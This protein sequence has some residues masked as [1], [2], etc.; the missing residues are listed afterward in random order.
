MC[1]CSISSLS[2]GCISKV[3]Q[4]RSGPE[5]RVLCWA[6]INGEKQEYGNGSQDGTEQFKCF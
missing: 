3:N 2:C 1:N 5:F 6:A 4:C